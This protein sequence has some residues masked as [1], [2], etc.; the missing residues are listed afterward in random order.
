[1]QSTVLISRLDQN[2]ECRAVPHGHQRSHLAC[3]KRK[4][5]KHTFDDI[6]SHWHIKGS[7]MSICLLHV[8]RGRVSRVRFH[9]LCGL[10][11]PSC[12]MLF[13]FPF[14]GCC[15]CREGWL[16][17][18]ACCASPAGASDLLVAVFA[19]KSYQDRCSHLTPHPTHH[20][21]PH[22]SQPPH[23]TPFTPPIPS[24]PHFIPLHPPR[25]T[26]SYPTHSHHQRRRIPGSLVMQ[27]SLPHKAT[28][29]RCHGC[30]GPVC[31][32]LLAHRP[33]D[34]EY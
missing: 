1:M 8:L 28:A 30:M 23:P 17:L 19:K 2:F 16:R 29:L 9:P 18:Y 27:F 24:H 15:V 11:V 34:I 33:N 10:R 13:C 14:T 22:P 3:E 6:V 4:R 31:R 5:Q 20:T 32:R 21:L 12:A 25:P 26:P 7:Q